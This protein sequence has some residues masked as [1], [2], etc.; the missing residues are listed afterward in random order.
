MKNTLAL[1]F[2]STNLLIVTSKVNAQSLLKENLEK[3]VYTL[4]DDSLQGRQAGS[5]FSQKAADYIINQFEE[6][7]IPPFD[8][9]DYLQPFDEDFN[10]IV[11]I[12]HGNDA[13]LKDEYIVVGA[14]YDHLGVKIKNGKEVIYNGADDNA[15]GVATLIELGRILK[16]NQSSLKRSVI[17]IA[18]DAEETGLNGSQ[19]FVNYSGIP[20]ENI[21]LMI[22]ADMVGWYKKSGY[23]NYS[24]TGTINNGNQI[25]SDKNLIPDGLKVTT[26]NFEK[27]MFTATDTE[28]F[29]K[30][31]IPTLAVT[32]GLKSPYHKPEDDADLI[33]Y[34]GMALIAEHLTNV[35]QAVSGYE[36]YSA[37]GKI[38]PKHTDTM[39]KF[40][41]GITGNI[42]SN[43]HYY[44]DGALD[45]KP[46]NSYGIGVM[47]QL[48][49]RSFAIRPEVY[50]EYIQAMH[51]DGTIK[52]NNITI[53]LNL[54]YQT[55]NSS[56]FC[57]DIFIGGYFSHKFSGK[58]GSNNLDFTNLY[59]RNEGG[60]NFG[61]DLQ[62]AMIRLGYVNRSAL[63]DF[64]R[65]KNVDNAH[66]Q[67]R[68]SYFTL[69][70]I[71]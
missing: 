57:V 17:L 40:L 63:T 34:E 36:D 2:I 53:P 23:V 50:Y 60:I 21:K 45:G 26:Q 64:T 41:F 10:N 56:M 52:T 70:Y 4:A 65:S 35:V 14:H 55:A 32:T 22:S 12:L 66:I 42:G 18:F 51:P 38:A 27:S 48:N 7:G 9:D 29:A 8:D 62:L 13:V 1:V 37:S 28:P 46:A 30:I 31:G 39:R 59:Y 11:G 49:M 69:T 6:I 61:F 15:S 47:T 33:D 24:G 19:Y 3:H 68:A 5:F 67:N 43:Y 20:F 58:Q 71:F 44:T 54:V 16:Q 25:V